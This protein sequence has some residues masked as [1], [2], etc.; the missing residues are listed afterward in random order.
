MFEPSHDIRSRFVAAL[1]L[2]L[3]AVAVLAG[4]ASDNVS[5]APAEGD[6]LRVVSLNPALTAILLALGAGD[7][8]VGVDSWS[9]EQRPELASLPDVGGLFD[10]SLEGVV[11]LEPDLVVLT[12]SVEQRDFHSQLEAL[13]IRVAGF[14]N[15]RFDEVLSN[16]LDLGVLV[17]REAEARAR[18][19]TI[20]A[21]RTAVANVAASRERV[22]CLVVLQRDPVFV[23]GASSF[24]DEMLETA[25][26]TNLGRKLGEGYPRA[27][28]EWVV[29]QAPD[30]V[31]D[32]SRD[33]ETQG[34]RDY[35]Q[36]WKA[37]PAVKT[38][39]VLPIDAE[40][41]TL[42]GPA[43][44]GALRELARALHGAT[45]EAEIA[46]ALE[47]VAPAASAAAARE[48]GR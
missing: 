14:E 22:R 2:V 38:G 46:A 4:A 20:R 45:V 31:F 34:V 3:L 5:V 10:P 19:L 36:R 8:L 27:A 21:T 17:D 9:H 43:L 44:D 7:T 18:V 13:G 1:G 25:G 11:A 15:I 32:T 48:A 35:W 28:L 33:A 26:C 41:L 6:R 39:R 24:I 16:I 29:A 40:K 12:P 30:V 42:P 47:V 37:L 23:V